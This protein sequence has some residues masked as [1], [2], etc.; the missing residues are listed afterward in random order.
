MAALAVPIVGG[1]AAAAL[2]VM[3][4]IRRR[5]AQKVAATH[6]VDEAEPFLEA[7]R[8]QFLASVDRGSAT[9]SER[10]QALQT[11][12]AVWSQVV[13]E[14]SA[15]GG[16][17]GE[18]CISDRQPGGQWDWFAMYRT[19]VERAELSSSSQVAPWGEAW[20]GGSAVSPVLAVLGAGLI[21]WAVA[22]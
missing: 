12:D 2:I 4:W 13:R 14:C 9:P 1:V 5:N 21:A 15:I 10:A 11:F 6:V 20:I 3:S 18:R 17:G 19:P 8:D 7:N 22:S 16:G